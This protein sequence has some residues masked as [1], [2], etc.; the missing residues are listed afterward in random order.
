MAILN[1]KEIQ[2]VKWE[3][4]YKFQKQ[5]LQRVAAAYGNPFIDDLGRRR[6]IQRDNKTL[7]LG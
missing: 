1:Y 2:V 7:W 5:K 3:K 4:C 6:Q